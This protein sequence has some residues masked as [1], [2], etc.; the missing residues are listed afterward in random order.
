VQVKITGRIDRISLVWV[1]VS[2]LLCF[3]RRALF[4][5]HHEGHFYFKHHVLFSPRA[6]QVKLGVRCSL[7]CFSPQTS[8]RELCVFLSSV[9]V[10][11]NELD[12]QSNNT[13]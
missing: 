9:F 5:A 11:W 7:E 12:A 3:P 6:R 4:V 10:S 13:A 8:S 1:R 2:V